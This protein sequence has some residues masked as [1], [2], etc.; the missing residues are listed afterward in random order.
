MTQPFSTT[1]TTLMN[2]YLL[3]PKSRDLY[4]SFASPNVQAAD[5]QRRPQNYSTAPLSKP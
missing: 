4:T 1:L 2:E 3:G 5:L